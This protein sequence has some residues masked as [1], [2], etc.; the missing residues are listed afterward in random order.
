METNG[1][2]ESEKFRQTVATVFPSTVIPSELWIPR[3]SKSGRKSWEIDMKT[4][5]MRTLIDENGEIKSELSID[6]SDDLEEKKEKKEKKMTRVIEKNGY[7]EYNGIPDFMKKAN[8]AEIRSIDKAIVEKT[9]KVALE[10][11]ETLDQVSEERILEAAASS[12]RDRIEIASLRSILLLETA[13]YGE[14]DQKFYDFPKEMNKDQLK[15]FKTLN[16]KVVNFLKKANVEDEKIRLEVEGLLKEGKIDEAES[17]LYDYKYYL[18]ETVEKAKKE[19]LELK[20]QWDEVWKVTVAEK[21]EEVSLNELKNE[22]EKKIEEQ[23]KKFEKTQEHNKEI[24]TIRNEMRI[25]Q[26][27]VDY[28]RYRKMENSLKNMATW[29]EERERTLAWRMKEMEM[30]MNR[31]TTSKNLLVEE[32]NDYE[33]LFDR[34]IDS[35]EEVKRLNGVVDYLDKRLEKME[36][37]YEMIVRK[38]GEEQEETANELESVKRE[39]MEAKEE[40]E[41]FIDTN[42]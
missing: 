5:K 23:K 2:R 32:E 35:E 34:F 30:K 39:L 31:L 9:N 38:M 36:E 25:S 3:N 7:I 24:E 26:T 12:I 15:V 13:F 17:L 29:Y 21:K 4:M 11:K 10:K 19:G 1:L 6:W 33:E 22:M 40:L 20:R 16:Q 41:R 14:P 8:D 28:G 18:T 27:E 37:R 42:I